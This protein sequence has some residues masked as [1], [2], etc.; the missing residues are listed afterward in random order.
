MATQFFSP[1]IWDRTMCCSVAVHVVKG[2]GWCSKNVSQ[3]SLYSCVIL[4]HHILPQWLL[5]P[6]QTT[7]QVDKSYKKILNVGPR[8][9]AWLQLTFFPFPVGHPIS[10]GCTDSVR[11]S[12][13]TASYSSGFVCLCGQRENKKEMSFKTFGANDWTEQLWMFSIVIIFLWCQCALDT[14]CS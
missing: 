13:L 14:N 3:K 7:S 9:K 4:A 10:A 1:Q 2:K 12:D 8:Q 11:A 5:A 6:L